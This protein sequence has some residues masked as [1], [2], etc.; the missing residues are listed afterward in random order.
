MNIYSFYFCHM[1]SQKKI[2]P[3][4][5]KKAFL[6]KQMLDDN[7]EA[8]NQAKMMAGVLRTKINKVYPMS[9]RTL[10]RY[11]NIANSYTQTTSDQLTLF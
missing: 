5:I 11:I 10:Q 6:V 2:H 1:L 8:G 3:N 7:Y 4:T 9:Y